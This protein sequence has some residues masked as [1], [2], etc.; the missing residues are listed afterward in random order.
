MED[1]RWYTAS[2]GTI[3]QILTTIY[4]TTFTKMKLTNNQKEWI[5]MFVYIFIGYL[6]A[7]GANKGLSYALDTDYPV[8]A[9]VSGSMEH[10][11]PESTYYPFMQEK[12]YSQDDLKKFSFADGMRKGDIA[13]IRNIP[14]EKLKVGDVIVYVVPGKEPIIHR[15]VEINSEGLITKGDNNGAIDQASGGIAPVIKAENVKGKAIARAPMLG[16]VKL[17]YMKLTGRI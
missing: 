2:F 7:V 13:V 14:F 17:T 4:F 5:E 15:V 6:I 3:Y 8:V 16:Y 12:G 11:N 9:V 10:G 1:S